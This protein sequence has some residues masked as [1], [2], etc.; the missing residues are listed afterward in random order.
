MPVVKTG[1]F[2]DLTGEEFDL[3]ELER[4]RFPAG[5]E[6][7]IHEDT[8]YIRMTTY[9]ATADASDVLTAAVEAVNLI[10]G[11]GQLYVQNWKN[12]RCGGPTL[13]DSEGKR[14]IFGFVEPLLARTRFGTPVVFVNG[15]P[16]EPPA[17]APSAEAV[18]IS[19][20]HSAVE[21][22]LRIYGSSALTFRDLYIVYEAIEHDAGGLK[23]LETRG[24][25]TKSDIR[26]FKHTANSVASLGDQARHGA[27]P[28]QPPQ[29]PFTLSQ[30][31]QLIA[32]LARSW[33]AA[34]R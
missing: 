33:I 32:N 22:V 16:A 27:E 28:T 29:D 13:V 1:W 3:H 19:D 10:N 9:S 5:T 24:W 25:V 21:K 18:T 31:R 6:L 30:A 26:R 12:I 7:Y 11:T 23:S 14:H 34:K 20:T 17:P 15:R 2:V 4:L 8:L